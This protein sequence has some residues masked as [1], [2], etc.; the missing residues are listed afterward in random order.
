LKFLLNLIGHIKEIAVVVFHGWLAH[1]VC[2]EEEEEE[3][4][5]GRR[6]NYFFDD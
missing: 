1:K 4:E 3:E 5:G 2:K 6:K